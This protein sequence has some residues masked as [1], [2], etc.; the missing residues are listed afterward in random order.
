MLL[1]GGR[2]SSQTGEMLRFPFSQ[3]VINADMYDGT[4]NWKY[5]ETL[6][7]NESVIY[8]PK[9]GADWNAWYKELKDY[10]AFVRGHLNDTSAYFIELVFDKTKKTSINFNKTA[11]DMR[12]LP[13]EHIVVD[14]VLEVLAGRVKVFVDL[15]FKR[16]GE[17]ISNPVR[18]TITAAGYFLADG[19]HSSFFR[20]LTLPHFNADSFSVAP[21]VRIE[22]PDTILTRVNIRS[23]HLSFPSSP[24]RLKRYQELAEMFH[25][26]SE[27]IDRQLY[28]RP[29][30]QWLKRNFIM[31]FAFIWDNDFWDYKTG[32][33]KIKAWCDR[34]KKEF[35]DRKSV[36]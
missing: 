9:P 32:K 33:Y 10:Q 7:H 26:A 3:Y 8:P 20:E 36:V 24:V 12:L 31:G 4:S 2:A 18:K 14:G 23:L 1:L 15:Q 28:D 16:K 17:E 34:M 6:A 29:E 27:K 5:S 35:G 30:M 22:A 11:F 19:D 21:V 25:P 13:D